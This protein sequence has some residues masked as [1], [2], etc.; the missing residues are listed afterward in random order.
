MLLAVTTERAE[1]T[2]GFWDEFD[3]Q[4]FFFSSRR[5]HTSW[6]GDWSSDVCSSDLALK[7]LTLL[8][9]HPAEAVKS[10]IW[11][12]LNVLE[13]ATE[14]GVDRFVN[15]STDKAA[16]PISV[17]GYSKRIEIGRAHV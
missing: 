1:P 8:E 7:H 6:T 14:A 9:R 4:L 16:D 5:P 10:N 2:Q 11:G 12:T 15:I 13:A 3:L 17:L